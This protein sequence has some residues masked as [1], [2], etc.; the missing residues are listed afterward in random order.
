MIPNAH[1]RS[2]TLIVTIDNRKRIEWIAGRQD[3]FAETPVK[4]AQD[5]RVPVG[6]QSLLQTNMARSPVRRSIDLLA[7]EA[8]PRAAEGDLS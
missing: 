8:V 7:R 6:N 4:I 5:A 1:H 3:A 2:A